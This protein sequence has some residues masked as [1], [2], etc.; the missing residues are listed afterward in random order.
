MAFLGMERD[1]HQLPQE[2]HIANGEQI[3]YGGPTIS[4]TA[5]EGPPLA[6]SGSESEA[7]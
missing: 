3:V 4:K 5:G 2:E 6:L 7:I 1:Q